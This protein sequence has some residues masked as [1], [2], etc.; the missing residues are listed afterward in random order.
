M[1]F[2]INNNSPL[3]IN[4]CKSTLARHQV[5][6]V[7]WSQF[8]SLMFKQ[9]YISRVC[10]ISVLEVTLAGYSIP[11]LTPSSTTK[12]F[13]ISPIPYPCSMPT[14]SKK[15]QA[16]IPSVLA[17]WESTQSFVHL[18]FRYVKSTSVI[19]N[20]FKI[21]LLF[22]NTKFPQFPQN[23]SPDISGR[24]SSIFTVRHQMSCLHQLLLSPSLN[25]W[26]PL[27]LNRML[28][29]VYAPASTP[30]TYMLR[31]FPPGRN[32]QSTNLFMSKSSSSIQVQWPLSWRLPWTLR[33][34]GSFPSFN[35][36]ALSHSIYYSVTTPHT[37]LF[38][39]SLNF[40]SSHNN[41]SVSESW[42]GHLL[43]LWP[44]IP[45]L[46]STSS[47][48]LLIKCGRERFLLRWVS[49]RI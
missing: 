43:D 25:F 12:T 41:K 8:S 46:T 11:S 23:K 28:L 38:T 36:I 21:K 29:P 24:C 17:P 32:P 7:V 44:G 3:W 48:C 26:S 10:P 31:R 22:Q 16:Y 27:K 13:N 1:F 49:M 30:W 14:V 33:Q 4:S 20:L 40:L 39:I 6:S 37:E 18:A 34:K 42:L 45:Y 9:L 2:I 19:F 35:P 15:L 47:T 5:Y